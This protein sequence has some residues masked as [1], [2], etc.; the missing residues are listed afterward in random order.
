MNDE[1]DATAARL[2]E[3][4]RREA[5]ALVPGPPPVLAVVREGRRIRR[6]RH[7]AVAASFF[8]VLLLPWAVTAFPRADTGPVG[9][10]MAGAP[11]TTPPTTAARVVEPYE[12]VDIGTGWSIALRPPDRPGV[13]GGQGYV[14]VAD[15][16]FATATRLLADD[17]EPE[18]E[19]D[20]P[21]DDLS[22][23]MTVLSEVFVISGTWRTEAGVPPAYV[24]VTHDEVTRAATLL[25][26]PDE[27][28]WGVYY[29][30]FER[31]DEGG[32]IERALETAAGVRVELA[33]AEGHVIDKISEED[34]GHDPLIS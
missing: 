29:A 8:A 30:V 3:R 10:D 13:H 9:P 32:L 7:L 21:G 22:G 26:V 14:L 20:D 16:D 19:G 6:R 24:T 12:A 17:Q 1:H 18:V 23:F 25:R 11:G 31:T 2:G 34:L 5:D 15:E 28:G 33:G 4:L 27:Q